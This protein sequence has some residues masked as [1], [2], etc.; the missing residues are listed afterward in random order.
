MNWAVQLQEFDYQIEHV[1]GTPNLV[2]NALQR[3]P[4][5]IIAHTDEPSE[6]MFYPSLVLIQANNT[7]K[8]ARLEDTELQEII[9]GVERITTKGQGKD[10]M[11]AEK[12]KL[13]EYEFHGKPAI[14]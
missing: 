5:K 9:S 3:Q 10:L 2:T 13:D 4:D 14:P 12:K 1:R 11:P 8:L 7:I 6:R